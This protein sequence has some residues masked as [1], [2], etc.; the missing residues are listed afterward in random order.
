V[1]FAPATRGDKVGR[2]LLGLAFIATLATVL[3]GAA[4]AA[5]HATLLSSRPANGDVLG[6]APER[7]ELDFSE[8]IVPSA[9]SV[10]LVDQTGRS[11]PSGSTTTSPDRLHLTVR[12]PRLV[13]GTY[14]L[15]WRTLAED[16]GHETSGTIVFSVGAP[17]PGSTLASGSATTQS[18]A[19]IVRRWTGILALA[20]LLGAL[21]LT[22]LLHVAR[23]VEQLLR[24]VRTRL[25]TIALVAVGGG[26]AVGL[27]DFVVEQRRTTRPI[28]FE[29]AWS[30]L[31][32]RWGELW[33]ARVLALVILG[34]VLV[35]VR[36]ESRRLAVAGVLVAARVLTEAM[37]GHAAS[38]TPRPAA[39]AAD[40][41]HIATASVWL[42]SV[43]C[44]VAAL[45]A[46]EPGER[47]A[48]AR[49][50]RVPFSVLM[51][52]A[53]ALAVA[54]GLY[55]AGVEVPS[56]AAATGTTYGRTLLIKLGALVVLCGVAARNALR[57]HRGR[58]PLRGVAVEVTL[59]VALFAAAAVLI[60]TAPPTATS[61]GGVS[62]ATRAADLVVDARLDPTGAG[63]AAVTAVV[64][65]SRRPPPAPVTTVR[66]RRDGHTVTL[67]RT[68]VDRYFGTIP[69]TP[70]GTVADTL[71]IQRGGQRLEVPLSW[72]D[73][74]RG[75][76]SLR[77]VTGVLAA[78]V[79]VLVGVGG[80]G[81]RRLRSNRPR[82]GA[83]VA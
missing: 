46:A 42:G 53:A 40:T 68:G 73:R 49:A 71:L 25:R 79:L 22:A 10:R 38:A 66:L 59:A 45:R 30:V 54:S 15:L 56:L 65:S 9:S 64:A 6:A 77:T 35:A 62:T 32:T 37:A 80:I 28:S 41:V 43:L 69:G 60:E 74:G 83:T 50:Y 76:T 13:P 51:A 58:L 19:D 48:L 55:S 44:A 20:V 3:V 27:W 29:T 72:P 23:G 1:P 24:P 33:L 70:A 61:H 52:F 14:G 7:A 21:A 39:I 12:L 8:T 11:M 57:L 63:S 34:A 26:L 78:T 36:P 16:D 2:P 47:V 75:A 17:D 82:E 18:I 67:H 31:T 81:L 5:A 4:P